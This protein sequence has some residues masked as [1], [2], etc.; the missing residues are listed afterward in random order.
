MNKKRH[1]K[2]QPFSHPSSRKLNET[3]F[4]SLLLLVAPCI[5]YPHL[6]NF[7]NLPK[8]TFIQL[9][10]SAL[11]SLWFWQVTKT[12]KF[13]IIMHPTMIVAGI[14]LIW[15]GLTILWAVDKFSG[16]LLW[17]HWG[18]CL[19]CFVVIVQVVDSLT[20]ID[21]IILFCV[22]GLS[23]IAGI[24]ILQ[25]LLG[26]DMIPQAAAPAATFSN[27]NVAAQSVAMGLPL[28]L[29]GFFLQQRP[30]MY[31]LFGGM[32]SVLTIFLFYT[33]T[34]A[35]WIAI[36]VSGILLL[37]VVVLTGLWRESR[38]FFPRKKGIAALLCG[39]FIVLMINLP[40]GFRQEH[41]AGISGQ[42]IESLLDD[43]VQKKVSYQETLLSVVKID[44]GTARLRLIWWRNTLGMIKDHVLGG[45]GFMNWYV[46]YP[47][48]HR[49]AE[50]DPL[51][52]L[53]SQPLRLHNDWLQILA[54][55][56]VIGCFLYAAMFGILI[57]RCW[58][59][60]RHACETEILLRALFL[61]M[62][63]S[64]FAINSVFDFPFY[65][66]LPPLL[67]TSMMGSLVVI[68]RHALKTVK[69]ITISMNALSINVLRGGLI[70]GGLLLT[71][72]NG[73]LWLADHHYLRSTAFHQTGQWPLARIEAE[74]ARDLIPWRY[75]IWAELATAYHNLG[76]MNEA[77]AGS[78]E[79][80]RFHPNHVN[81]LFK[82]AYIAL[83]T[84]DLN[85]TEYWIERVLAITPD[86][87]EALCMRGMVAEQRAQLQNAQGYYQKAINVNP[88]NVE[89]LA[90]LGIIAFREKRLADA[91]RYFQDVLQYEPDRYGAYFNLGLVYTALKMPTQAI[92]AYQEENKRHP[93][94]PDAL[95]NLGF[96]WTQQ[97]EWQKSIQ[98][99]TEA[100]RLRPEA[101][102]IHLALADIYYQL[103]QYALAWKHAK[104]A[105]QS[106]VTQAA[107]FIANLR[108]VS[109]ETE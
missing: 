8:T 108:T 107:A 76:R 55:T 74:T 21:H 97:Q 35:A 32:S 98:A 63:I 53:K 89:A 103:Q 14:W 39:M 20:E 9:I 59:I 12:G 1:Q 88:Q 37:V 13:Q 11:V 17:L 99:Y 94:N 30:V 36:G 86:F 52:S 16:M 62:T 18:T 64:C 81:S 92:Q 15:S 61:M 77:I 54:E 79:A 27:K 10:V 73:R 50:V 60:F 82:L 78:L 95:I 91:Q 24:G 7:S 65:M 31:G 38:S 104:I 90:R 42:P 83:N 87:D 80:L 58:M 85:R 71:I 109:P 105:E 96:L 67:F 29:L 23:L 66:A 70:A 106:G 57:W 28:A 68:E 4:I 22:T 46:F 45:V 56:S 43:D 84:G 102:Q 72:F 44:Q 93:D 69:S 5:Y 26:L 33:R 101:G 48:Y 49:A 19:L 25:Y 41:V 34:R 100:L 3:L 47:L 51:F 6:E 75:D 40:P 2:K